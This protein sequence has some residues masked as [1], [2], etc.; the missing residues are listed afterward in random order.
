MVTATQQI[1]RDSVL[2]QLTKEH[3]AALDDVAGPSMPFASEA[4]LRRAHENALEDALAKFDAKPLVGISQDQRRQ[5]REE[6][7][8]KLNDAYVLVENDAF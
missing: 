4:R 8:E 1:Q 2:G 3:Q 6:L 5:M 7:E